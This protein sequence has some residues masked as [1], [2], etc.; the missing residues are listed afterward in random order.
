MKKV[1]VILMAVAMILT[2]QVTSLAKKG[3]FVESPSANPAP[4]LVD[5]D[6]EPHDCDVS[7]TITPYALRDTLSDE[8]QDDME[9]AFSDILNKDN[10]SKFVDVAEEIA[11]ESSVPVEQLSVSD[12]FDITLNDCEIHPIEE[13]G[14]FVITLKSDTFGKLAGVAYF[15]EGEWRGAEAELDETGKLLTIHSEHLCPFAIFVDAGVTPP[16]TSDNSNIYLWVMLMSA[17]GLAIILL[18]LKKKKV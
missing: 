4:E 10:S 15:W 8:G 16:T 7:V 14:N 2:L 11:K 6:C 17:S 1:I 18:A 9:K 13:H 5:F 12:L 3:K